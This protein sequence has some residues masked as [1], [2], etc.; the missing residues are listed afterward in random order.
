[1]ADVS[2]SSAGMDAARKEV[3]SVRFAME[4]ETDEKTPEAG[5]QH[6]RFLSSQ[7]DWSREHKPLN[8]ALK[9]AAS[10]NHSRQRPAP[11]PMLVDK[12]RARSPRG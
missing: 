12:P 2:A 8:G 5:E 1:M 4:R 3:P 7:R 6:P 9:G 11:R 10:N